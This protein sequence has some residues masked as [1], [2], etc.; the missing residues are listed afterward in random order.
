MKEIIKPALIQSLLQVNKSK[1]ALYILSLYQNV[2]MVAK[3][4]L[5]VFDPEYVSKRGTESTSLQTLVGN[6]TPHCLP[7]Q[8]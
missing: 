4:S 2:D 3:S 5:P 6:S 1:Q 8:T 7:V